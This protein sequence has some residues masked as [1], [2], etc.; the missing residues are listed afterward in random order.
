M[1]DPVF[2]D[3]V[4]PLNA[5]NMT[6]LQTRDEKGAVSGYASLDATGKVP[7]AQLPQMG[8]SQIPVKILNPRTTSLAGQAFFLVAAFTNLD[9]GAW[10]F[11]Q[12]V[13]GRVYGIARLSGTV[14]SVNV[15]LALCAGVAGVSRMKVSYLAL[16]DGVGLGGALTAVASQD[17]SL[18]AGYVQKDALFA[19]SGLSTYTSLGLEITHEGA[20]ANDTLA[21]YTYLLDASLDV[22]G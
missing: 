2:V 5:A 13:E 15:R 17:L 12:D 6:K 14:A 10:L 8:V 4:T 11:A 18:A 19:I 16:K 9:M 20:H 1:P 22:T 7:T 3:D 21:G